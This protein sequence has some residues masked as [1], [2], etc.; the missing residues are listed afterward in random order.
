MLIKY[1][2]IFKCFNCFWKVFYFEKC[3]IFQKLCNSILVTCLVSQAN[4]M[5]QSRAY[6]EGFRDSLAGQ[7][8][9]R[10]KNLK[11]SPKIW[12]SRFLA[13]L[14]GDLFASGSFSREVYSE[15]F[16]APFATSSRVDLPVAKNTLTNFSKFCHKGFWQLS[17]ATCLQL[18]S[19]TN[20]ACFAL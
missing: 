15:S 14:F 18:I 3:K 13:T 1:K 9:S 6:T 2:K 5:P 10:K 4:C 8:P 12:I 16:V 17:L 19:V 20:I 11:I 7:C